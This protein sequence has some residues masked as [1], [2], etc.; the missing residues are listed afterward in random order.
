M[1]CLFEA[2][3]MKAATGTKIYNL[4][5]SSRQFSST[6]KQDGRN[7]FQ[8]MA[9]W[10]QC[11]VCHLCKTETLQNVVVASYLFCQCGFLGL[12][13][14]FLPFLL[15]NLYLPLICCNCYR[16]YCVVILSE[17]NTFLRWFHAISSLLF[18]YSTLIW[19]SVQDPAAL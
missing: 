3:A 7:Q 5:I 10:S 13:I 4:G 6:F 1:H 19:N 14:I 2:L 18:V 11:W 9:I 17:T 12:N 15:F 8:N 16:W